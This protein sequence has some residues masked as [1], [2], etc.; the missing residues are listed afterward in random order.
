MPSGSITFEC[1]GNNLAEITNNMTSF[2][3][4]CSS[5]DDYPNVPQ[6]NPDTSFT[7]PQKLLKSM[8]IQTKFA[9][10]VVDSKP[11]LMG[12][13]FEL[14][15]NVLSVAAVDGVRIALRQEPVA[16]DNIS[17]IVPA[18]TLEELTHILSDE[19]Q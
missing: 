13:K 19:N 8:I 12:C 5:A 7:M 2:S 16:Y 1:S 9:V 10:A 14:E 4:S 3:V 18:K 15:N 6:V 17:F 11:A